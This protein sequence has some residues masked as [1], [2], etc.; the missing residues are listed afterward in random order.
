MAWDDESLLGLRFWRSP[1]VGPKRFWQAYHHYGSIKNAY[2]HI[3]LLSEAAV[4]EEITQTEVVGAQFVFFHHFPYLL[5]RIPDVPPILVVKGKQELWNQSCLGIVGARNASYAG[6]TMA[7]NLAKD[8]GEA[9]HITVSGLARG[10]DGAVHE[11]S[12]TTGTIAVVAGGVDVIYPQEHEKLYHKIAKHGLIVAEMALGTMPKPQLFPRRNR[13][14]AGLS[15]AVIVVEAGK[16]SGSIITAEYA[17]KYGRDVMAVPG[18]PV[19]TRTKGS[20]GLLRDGATLVESAE[21]C[22]NIL[23]PSLN[24]TPPTPI[25]L[26]VEEEDTHSSTLLN[27]LSAIPV[28]LDELIE[29]HPETSPQQILRHLGELMMQGEVVDV[30]PGGRYV[31]TEASL[32]KNL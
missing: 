11:A 26:N 13:L 27:D 1:D 14:I 10:I 19:D 15:R 2:G 29:L 6:K 24:P 12:Y 23:S 22:L 32:Q 30:P 25:I 18:S 31:R 21:D 8:L 4:R 9:G 16:P 5:K 3:P 28:S 20:N 17:L 7:R